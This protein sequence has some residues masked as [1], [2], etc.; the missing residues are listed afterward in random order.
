MLPTEPVEALKREVQAASGILA[1]EQQLLW[2]SGVLDDSSS[3]AG[4]GVSVGGP[5]TLV[6]V[7]RRYILAGGANG[8]L[9]ILD[10]ADDSYSRS[11]PQVHFRRV[12]ALAAD[13]NSQRAVSGT[14]DQLVVWDLGCCR[15]V[16][17]LDGFASAVRALAVDWAADLALAG[18][19][20]GVIFLFR[21]DGDGS[22]E[23]L[24]Y[25]Q[26]CVTSISADWPGSRAL[27]ASY[28]RTIVLWDLESRSPMRALKGHTGVVLDVTA[29]W[30]QGRA[31]SSSADG[32]L[33]LWEF[34]SGSSAATLRGHFA[35][36]R[37]VVT[38]WAS[39][40]ALSGSADKLLILWLIGQPGELIVPVWKLQGHL[41][42]VT[43][44]AVDWSSMQALS[45]A[46]DCRVL[47]WDLDCGVTLREVHRGSEVTTLAVHWWAGPFDPSGEAASSRGDRVSEDSPITPN[48]DSCLARALGDPSEDSPLIPNCSGSSARLHNGSSNL[49]KRTAQSRTECLPA[50]D[51]AS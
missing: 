12:D 43:A 5:V 45:A 41:G 11:L 35:A 16:R 47:L 51:L 26:G 30:S 31:L 13:W 23:R 9:L 2:R 37:V 6:R 19:G 25:H 22:A 10:L 34:E 50:F 42:E 38:D 14:M 32:T 18:F 17:M 15:V 44:L 21:I 24:Q 36:V 1:C 3:L 28:D 48:G 7:A 40:R 39:S 4:S 33:M 27:S 46:R 8:S 49:G 20:D 29:D